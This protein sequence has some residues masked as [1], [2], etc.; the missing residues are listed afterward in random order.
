MRFDLPHVFAINSERWIDGRYC[1]EQKYFQCCDRVVKLVRPGFP[2]IK[3]FA[4]DFLIWL[5]EEFFL[6]NEGYWKV[7][8]PPRAKSRRNMIYHFYGEKIL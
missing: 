8:S 6:T 7:K 2:W 3:I 4:E 5:D 1:H